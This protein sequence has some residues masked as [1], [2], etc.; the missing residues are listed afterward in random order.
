MKKRVKL[1]DVVWT[2]V[3][4]FFSSSLAHNNYDK[5]KWLIARNK[6]NTSTAIIK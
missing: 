2:S 5:M 3:N 4:I 1:T 6:E